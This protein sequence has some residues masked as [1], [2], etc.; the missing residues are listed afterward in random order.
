MSE[1]AGFH[2]SNIMDV[3]MLA[4]VGGRE[5]TPR[6]FEQLFSE[7]GFRFRRVIPTSSPVA[8]IVEAEAV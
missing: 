5:R 4:L 8:Q 1:A 3:S 7:N 2:A 6:Q